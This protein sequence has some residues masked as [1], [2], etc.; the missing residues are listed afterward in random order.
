MDQPL[1][2]RWNPIDRPLRLE[3]GAMNGDAA[4]GGKTDAHAHTIA[5]RVD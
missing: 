5:Q 4:I 2:P 3:D 1:R